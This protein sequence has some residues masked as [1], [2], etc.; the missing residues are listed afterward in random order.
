MMTVHVKAD[1]RNFIVSILDDGEVRIIKERKLYAPGRPYE[2]WYNAPYW[3][4]THAKGRHNS[5]VNR[6]IEA[7]QTKMLSLGKVAL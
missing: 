2:C 4:F 7:A 6:I 3:H 5:R 1:D